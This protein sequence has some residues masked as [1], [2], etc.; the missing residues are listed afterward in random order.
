MP[1]ASGLPRRAS[2]T[3]DCRVMEA[4]EPTFTPT[5]RRLS[6]AKKGKRVHLCEKCGKVFTRAE[7]LRRHQLNHYAHAVYNC[8]FPG[9]SRTFQRPDLLARHMGRH[10][11]ST[12]TRESFVVEHRPRRSLSV[13]DSMRPH[14]F[15]PGYHFGSMSSGHGNN[16]LHPAVMPTASD[17]PPPPEWHTLS[18]TPVTASN[19]EPPMIPSDVH[20]F[21]PA[22]AVT[23]SPLSTTF[24]PPPPSVSSPDPLLT[25]DIRRG[26][27]CSVASTYS[28]YSSNSYSTETMTPI[29]WSPTS[30]AAV[31]G[32][33]TTSA[34][35]YGEVLC[36]PT[37]TQVPNGLEAPYELHPPSVGAPPCFTTEAIAPQPLPSSSSSAWYQALC[38]QH[39]LPS[40]SCSSPTSSSAQAGAWLSGA[41]PPVPNNMLLGG[42]G[43]P[44][45]SSI[46]SSTTSLPH[47]QPHPQGHLGPGPG[48]GP[49][50]SEMFVWTRLDPFGGSR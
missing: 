7:H 14:A 44:P 12:G 21:Y 31:P 22:P 46:D 30:V 26:S 1:T 17:F 29:T 10:S 40:T 32:S 43:S 19:A 33:I 45:L 11:Q 38:Q 25:N 18:S 9:C 16:A 28:S 8:D 13:G 34:P 39:S 23:F 49:H 36:S 48:P 41:G 47:H 24:S 37:S 2:T 20:S 4:L 35:F 3:K 5:T 15:I 27:D 50:E 42:V 6:K